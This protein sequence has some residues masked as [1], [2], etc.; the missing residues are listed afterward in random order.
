[1]IEPYSP[2]S[3]PISGLGLGV[4]APYMNT[5]FIVCGLLVIAGAIGVRRTL[6]SARLAT[7]GVVVS[8]FMGLGMVIDGIFTLES[9]LMHL[10]GFLVA[11]P[12]T[13]IGFLLTGLVVRTSA[14]RLSAVLI[15]SGPLALGLF[16]WFMAIFDPYSAGGNAGYAGL[17]QRAAI[18]VV[19]AAWTILGITTWR[20]L[21]AP[22]QGAR[23]SPA[24]GAGR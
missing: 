15:V 5:A 20:R 13:A 1:M 9:M 16:A 2:V 22:R 14:P 3:Q 17:V 11:V 4:T 10:L 7:A 8:A 23:P 19:A 12:G 18:T 21:R 24:P 6:P